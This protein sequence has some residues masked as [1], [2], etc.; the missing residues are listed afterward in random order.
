MRPTIRVFFPSDGCTFYGDFTKQ[1][2]E[3]LQKEGT[4]VYQR[5]GKWYA[6][7]EP[8]NDIKH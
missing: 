7:P 6:V 2:F 5:D 8:D 3:N 4:Q 1:E